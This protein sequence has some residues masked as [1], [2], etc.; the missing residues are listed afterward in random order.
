[1]PV[2]SIS[3]A[4]VLGAG[5]F[6]DVRADVFASHDMFPTTLARYESGAAASGSTSFA[7]AEHEYYFQAEPAVATT[8]KQ[9]SWWPVLYSALVPGLG[10]LTMGYEKRG[11]ALM[12]VEAAAWTGYI[13]NHEDGLDEREA[14]EAF[15]DQYWTQRKFID[16]HPLIYPLPDQTQ[17]YLEE[18]GR[19]VSGSGGDW[20]TGYIPWVSKEEDKQHYYENIGKYDWFVSGWSDYDPTLDPP[21]AQSEKRE[22]YRAMRATSNES[23]DDA[24]A[25]VWVS[26]AARAFS[27]VETAIIVHNRR[28]E[29]GRASIGHETPVALRARPR[30]FQGGELALEVRFK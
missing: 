3:L 1:M 5:A 4:L 14:Y 21:L 8:T 26:V 29:G 22:E 2:H 11:I 27:L 6:A 19:A 24:N 12:L 23:L 16:D 28:E 9:Q 13:V 7:S 17:E 18:Q 20:W 30:G 10:E 15:A 25:F